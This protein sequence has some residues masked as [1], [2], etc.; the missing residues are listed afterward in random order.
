MQTASTQR[1]ETEEK[2]FV[3]LRVVPLPPPPFV[4]PS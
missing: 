3:S 1:A 2:I 4:A